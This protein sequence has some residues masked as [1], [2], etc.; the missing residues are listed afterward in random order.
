MSADDVS[1]AA[2]PDVTTLA[3]TIRQGV[4][5]LASDALNLAG[6]YAEEDRWRAEDA[7][8]AVRQETDD[9]LAVLLFEV[10]RRAKEY[11]SLRWEIDQ[12]VATR[13]EEERKRA[14]AL[15][16]EVERLRQERDKFREH[17]DAWKTIA[18]DAK[19]ELEAAQQTIVD[20]QHQMRE[21][22]HDVG[23]YKAMY[24]FAEHR[25]QLE[26]KKEDL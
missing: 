22:H 13:I 8:K 3:Q 17:K 1:P 12:A 18:E 15:L 19:R 16:A 6:T 10:E 2:V 24:L 26:L 7:V 20:L 23:T 14:D 11:E 4:G 9:A 5:A 21:L 25:L